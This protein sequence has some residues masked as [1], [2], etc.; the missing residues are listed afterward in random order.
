L[1][2]FSDRNVQKN[3]AADGTTKREEGAG[4]QRALPEFRTP[5]R[6]QAIGQVK[7]KR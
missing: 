4:K 3:K 5:N 1:Q 6:R 7:G 2:S